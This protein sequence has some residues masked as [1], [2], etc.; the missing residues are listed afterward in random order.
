MTGDGFDR[1]FSLS[2][3]QEYVS[4]RVNLVKMGPKESQDHVVNV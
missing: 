2:L 1:L 4:F 3:N